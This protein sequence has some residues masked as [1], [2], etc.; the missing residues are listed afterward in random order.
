MF[1]A[2]MGHAPL[3]ETYD[4]T[5]KIGSSSRDVFVYL[6]FQPTLQDSLF[7]GILCCRFGGVVTAQTEGLLR[8]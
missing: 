7:D 3:S 5:L 6:A 8:Y 4:A 1:L 2:G